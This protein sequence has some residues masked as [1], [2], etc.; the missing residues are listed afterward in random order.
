MNYNFRQGHFCIHK[1]QIFYFIQLHSKTWT[2]LEHRFILDFTFCM[3][4][5]VLCPQWWPG[6]LIWPLTS[7][8]GQSQLG[9]GAFYWWHQAAF[10]H[11]CL[12]VPGAAGRSVSIHAIHVFIPK[13]NIRMFFSSNINVRV[14]SLFV[15]VQCW[16]LCFSYDRFL[17][18]SNECS[19]LSQGWRWI[20]ESRWGDV[21]AYLG[22]KCP[23]DSVHQWPGLSWWKPE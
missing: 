16:R 15:D 1:F 18:M 2:G 9:G 19:L 23:E 13:Y 6:S 5:C 3:S 17:E 14:K 4:L 8:H 10:L 20:C 11:Q 22:Q 21:W 12:Q 7:G